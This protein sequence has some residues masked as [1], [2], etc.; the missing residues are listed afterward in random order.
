VPQTPR[1]SRGRQAKP[2]QLPRVSKVVPADSQ[3][4]HFQGGSAQ[5]SQAVRTQRTAQGSQRQSAG[6]SLP[7]YSQTKGKLERNVS[8]AAPKLAAEWIVCVLII[9]A[10]ALTKP[11]DYLTNMTEVLWRLTAVTAMFFVLAL[12][13]MARPMREITVAFGALIVLG[14]LYKS[15]QEIKTV[16]DEAGGLG[17]G[18]DKTQL[19]A[20]LDPDTE[21]KHNIVQ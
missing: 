7:S 3:G 4:G 10:T 13:S 19:T 16:L 18:E 9:G 8:S 2:A 20:D 5:R 12:A 1:R 15:S 11:G 21:P 17:S 6:S 14:I